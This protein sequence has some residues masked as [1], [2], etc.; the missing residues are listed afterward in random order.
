MLVADTD[1]VYTVK[2]V[3]ESYM[4]V[5]E[6]MKADAVFQ[7][8]GITNTGVCH[9][10]SPGPVVWHARIVG[11]VVLTPTFESPPCTC[12]QHGHPTH[13]PHHQNG[14]CLVQPVNGRVEHRK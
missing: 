14:R 11:L 4:N 5:L 8:E 12:R 1:I 2:S 10:C 3:W 6:V 9:A 7:E 13:P